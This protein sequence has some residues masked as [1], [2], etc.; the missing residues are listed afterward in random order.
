MHPH[1]VQDVSKITEI[2]RSLSKMSEV[3]P[4][5]FVG[6]EDVRKSPEDFRRLTKISENHPKTFEDHRRLLNITRT[7]TKISKN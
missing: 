4:T 2:N 5:I 1:V 3:Y 6:R 7:L